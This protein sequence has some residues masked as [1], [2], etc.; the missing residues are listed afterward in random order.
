MVTVLTDLL[1]PL[2]NQSGL[3]VYL[4]V[5]ALVFA[6]AGVLFGFVFPGETA[7]LLGGVVAGRHHASIEILIAVVVVCAI[8]GDSVGYWVG[9][10]FGSRV[11]GMRL[12]AKRQRAVDYTK[13]FL[14][15]RGA[16]AVFLGRFT[17]FLRAMIPGL[18]GMSEMHYGTFLP[19]NALGGVVWGAGFSLLGYAVGNAYAR[20][21]KYSS[22]ASWVLLALV[23]TGFVVLTIRGRRRE[24]RML[25]EDTGGSPEGSDTPAETDEVT[26]A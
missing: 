16:W 17:A 3:V 15:R 13:R 19:A 20:V 6:E 9:G 21:E 26:G 1:H 4:I 10:R 8:V 12:F 22:W 23:V 14:N 11:L 7:V 25:E 2:L 24:R 5:G 18:A